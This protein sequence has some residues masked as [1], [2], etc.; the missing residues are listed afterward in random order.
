MDSCRPEWS[1]KLSAWLDGEAEPAERAEVDGHLGRC[2]VCRRAVEAWRALGSRLRAG[3]VVPPVRAARRV[4]SWRALVAVAALLMVGIVA[5]FLSRRPNT[6]LMDEL[7]QHH[8]QAFAQTSPCEFQSN[9]PEAV[10]A[11]LQQKV[12]YA[13]DVPV[14]QGAT[15]LGARRCKLDGVLS[16]SLLF[17][18]GDAAVTVFVPPPGGALDP[19]FAKLT[20][21]GG[22]C[23]TG[24][25]GERVC[26][27]RQASTV[28]V[29]N[30]DP[31]T[32]VAFAD[33]VAR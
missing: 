16:A 5:T 13:V 18:R 26:T 20:A 25:L 19:M 23:V 15:L 12:G 14:V 29:S 21:G 6:P 3:A 8:F 22:R 24:R 30:T 1:E 11:W 32:L 7:E 9:D 10:R 17:R 28:A 2:L 31:G 33:A 4:P 27:S